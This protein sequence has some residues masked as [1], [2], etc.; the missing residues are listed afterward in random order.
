MCWKEAKV[1]QIELNSTYR[2]GK[3]SAHMCLVDHL[4]SHPSLGVRPIW[5]PIIT[6]DVRKFQL[7]PVYIMCEIQDFVLVL[8]R[9][10]L[11]IQ[12]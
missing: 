1:L 3:G 8:Y 6:V 5:T 9:E 10:F 4:I 11:S 2:K 12:G 7:R